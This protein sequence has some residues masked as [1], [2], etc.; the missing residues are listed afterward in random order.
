M[1]SIDF[2]INDNTDRYYNSKGISVPRVTD[3]LSTMIHSD[4]LMYWANSL[5]LKGIRYGSEMNRVSTLGT[6]AHSCIEKYLREKIK[7]DD[8]IP[9]QGYLLWESVLNSKGLYID[10]LYIE[11]KLVCEWF[12]G[13]ADAVL[14]IGSHTYLVDFKTSNYV[15]YKYFLQLAAYRYMLRLR[16]IDV[17]GVIVLQL[18]KEE[19][20]FNEYVLYSG[21]SKHMKFMQ[22]CENTFFSLV[23]AYYHIKNIE[24]EYKEIF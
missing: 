20:G 8:N 11:E 3:I 14:S 13:T 23:Y 19:P 1:K 16:G 12:G 5:G 22:D 21:I 10:P 15:T 24:R 7:T 9:F 4:R 6:N 2:A 18:N 17:D